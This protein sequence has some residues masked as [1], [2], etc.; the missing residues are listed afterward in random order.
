MKLWEQYRSCYQKENS[1]YEYYTDDEDL[2]VLDAGKDGVTEAHIQ[3]L[4]EL[5]R[6]ELADEQRHAGHRYDG[7]K[8]LNDKL[9]Y[10]AL[11]E[12]ERAYMGF[13]MDT[14]ANPETLLLKKEERMAMHKNILRALKGLREE[15][16]R[17]LLLVSLRIARASDIARERDV[18]KQTISASLSLAK[19]RFRKL[20]VKNP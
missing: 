17:I 14:E 15:P 20:F 12:D 8:T 6:K 2:I 3:E 7:E 9:N 1:H 11:T 16:R 5:H 4:K 18:S 10:D 13:F 19:K